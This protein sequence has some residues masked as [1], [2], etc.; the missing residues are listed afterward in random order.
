MNEGGRHTPAIFV[1]LAHWSSSQPMNDKHFLCSFIS[2]VQ[3]SIVVTCSLSPV[4]LERRSS[5]SVEL[6]S[7]LLAG[8]DTARRSM[9]VS[10]RLDCDRCV[11]RERFSWVAV[12]AMTRTINR[13]T[14]KPQ[15]TRT[16]ILISTKRNSSWRKFSK[17]A[18]QKK[19][20]SNVSR[21]S[22]SRSDSHVHLS[23]QIS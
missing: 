19:A 15:M 21:S 7:F 1:R 10:S 13:R 9:I 4:H 18:Q 6:F 17:C 20:K 5:V 12:L 2:P 14:S 3:N 16:P 22:S 8:I 11:E 23:L